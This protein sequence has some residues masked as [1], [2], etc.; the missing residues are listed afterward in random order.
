MIGPVTNARL[1]WLLISML[2]SAALAGVTA[3]W[4]TDWVLHRHADHHHA[5]DS[6][7]VADA[8]QGPSDL[9]A[10]MHKHLDLTPEQ[11]AAME[12]GEEDFADERERLGRLITSASKEL[13]KELGEANSPSPELAQALDKLHQAQGELQRATLNHFFA[14]KRYLRAGQVKKFREWTHDSLTR[15]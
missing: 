7:V 9:H 4:V 13:A 14:M 5:H 15:D 2:C 3:W 1:R 10:W 8:S 11:H 6:V 12:P